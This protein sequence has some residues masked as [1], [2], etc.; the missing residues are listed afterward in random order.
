VVA[1]PFSGQ[2]GGGKEN[3]Q[4]VTLQMALKIAD[5]GHT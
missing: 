4:L 3:K 5:L 1:S 2:F